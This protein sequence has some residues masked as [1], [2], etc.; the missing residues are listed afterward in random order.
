MTRRTIAEYMTDAPHTIG[1]DRTLAVARQLLGAHRQ[2]QL[3]VLDD[4]K[5]VGVISP[6]DLER[7]EG[8]WVALGARDPAPFDERWG[9]EATRARVSQA[10]APDPLVV[11]PDESLE[12]VASALATGGAPAAVVV[13]GGRV[14]G[15]FAAGD[16]LHALA[17]LLGDERTRRQRAQHV[18]ARRP[19]RRA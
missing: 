13:E 3:V 10:M 12:R 4:G 7:F 19:L 11:A 16:A 17:E 2:R 1:A 9:G 5:V 18:A 6:R 15:V 8:A 14:V